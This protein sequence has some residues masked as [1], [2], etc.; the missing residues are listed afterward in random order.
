MTI[1]VAVRAAEGTAMG[2]DLNVGHLAREDAESRAQGRAAGMAA[3]LK[4][5]GEAVDLSPEKPPEVPIK[6]KSEPVKVDSAAIPGLNDGIV[7]GV[8]KGKADRIGMRRAEQILGLKTRTVQK[9]SQRGELP[10]AAKMGRL[11]TYNEDKLH[12]YV[13]NQERAIW[14]GQSKHR[15]GVIGKT[16]S[17]ITASK[18]VASDSEARY[19]QAIQRSRNESAKRKKRN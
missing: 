5:V 10:G 9:M 19:S 13:R 17:C 1:T 4:F 18:S 7:T 15:Q 3:F 2:S 6:A 11:W 14:Q 16:T 8:A 12:G